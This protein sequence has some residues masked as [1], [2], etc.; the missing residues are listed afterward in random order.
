MLNKWMSFHAY[1][2]YFY[3]VFLYVYLFCVHVCV[4]I[5]AIGVGSLYHVSS[6]DQTQIRSLTA[7]SSH[8]PYNTAL[9]AAAYNN[10]L[11]SNIGL[12][13]CF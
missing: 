10:V 1:K 8:Q 3:H 12:S 6:K 13:G 11:K 9:V 4:S 5:H 7:E 2:L